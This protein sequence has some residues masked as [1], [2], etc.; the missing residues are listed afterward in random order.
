[1]AELSNE[2]VRALGAAANLDIQEPDLTHVANSLNA[3]LVAMDEIDIPGLNA[4]EP[5]PIIPP[6]AS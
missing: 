5:L 6:D 3:I 4:V 2:Q 1:M